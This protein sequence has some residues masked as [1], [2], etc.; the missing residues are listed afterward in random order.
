MRKNPENV[1]R[2]EGFTGGVNKKR[3]SDLLQNAELSRSINYVADGNG[4]LVRRPLEYDFNEALPAAVGLSLL[5]LWQWK[6]RFMPSTAS[7]LKDYLLIAYTSDEK[8]WVLTFTSNEEWESVYKPGGTGM[9]IFADFGMPR[10]AMTDY[11]VSLVD[12]RGNNVAKYMEVNSSRSFVFGDHGIKSPLGMG[13]FVVSAKM[14]KNVSADSFDKGM[15]VPRGHILF[16]NYTTISKNGVSSNPSPMTVFDTLQY[17]KLD[18]KYNLDEIWQ[19]AYIQNLRSVIADE[20]GHELLL[21]ILK[22][23]GIYMA[24]IPYCEGITPRGDLLLA[25]ENEILD[26]TGDNHYVLTNPFTGAAVS[27]DNDDQLK[28][29]DICHSGG[30]TTISNANSR[31]EF[32]FEFEYYW[33]IGI[34]NQNKRHYASRKYWIRISDS[35][36]VDE[37]GTQ[38]FNW[39]DA[40]ITDGN[41]LTKAAGNKLRLIDNDLRTFLATNYY[42]TEGNDYIDLEFLMPYLAGEQ[43]QTFYLLYAG[44]KEGVPEQSGT[45]T[46]FRTPKYG[47]WVDVRG[48]W[49]NE[50]VNRPNR[51][52]NSNCLICCSDE[53]HTDDQAENRADSGKPLLFSQGSNAIVWD[54]EPL[55]YLF[56]LG[57]AAKQLNI[58]S[59]GDKPTIKIPAK[60][61]VDSFAWIEDVRSAVPD[62]GFCYLFFK[63]G[64]DADWQDLIILG[65]FSAGYRSLSIQTKQVGGVTEIRLHLQNGV[66][67]EENIDLFDNLTSGPK[68]FCFS[69]DISNNKFY[70]YVYDINAEASFSVEETPAVYTLENILDSDFDFVLYNQPNGGGINYF[71]QVYMEKDL[72][73]DDDGAIFQ[74]MNMGPYFPEDWLG[75]DTSENKNINIEPG[76]L[77][78]FNTPKGMLRCSAPGGRTFPEGNYLMCA[79]STM[80]IM[81]MPAYLHNGE[82]LNTLLIFGARRNRQRL[83][84]RG[85][86]ATWNSTMNDVLINE[87]EEFALINEDAILMVGETLHYWA[88][89][90]FIREDGRSRTIL[91]L[92]A[93]GDERVTMPLSNFGNVSLYYIPATKQIVTT[94]LYD[95]LVHG[96]GEEYIEAGL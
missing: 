62:T 93:D 92:D 85:D 54:N 23:F 64:D 80:R 43:K 58:E 60:G 8:L 37:N 82:Y 26:L 18:D 12:G 40:A 70:A 66:M 67:T 14:N 11:G 22:Y 68:F 30:I 44:D 55:V 47:E 77:I 39:T 53:Y 42:Y 34:Y 1:I 52:K 25:V 3:R 87:Q 32:P 96:D 89:A 24:S 75:W 33:K 19:R 41:V 46:D 27:Y 13:D 57:T 90:G 31:L 65:D 4:R 78:E 21:D 16:L 88:P 10:L 9:E 20:D 63:E 36:L 76:K 73:L 56:P 50:V 38:V 51:V 95:V 35:D 15:N 6:P 94:V 84:M 48:S 2:L 28:G 29:D 59:S 86:P 5:R 72:Y 83:L 79:G 17:Q 45:Q 71:S 69:W 81:A 91:N 49:G 74:M 7:S 61:A